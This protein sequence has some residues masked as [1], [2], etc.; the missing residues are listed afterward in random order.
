MKLFPMVTIPVVA[1]ALTTTFSNALAQVTT[2][3]DVRRELIRAEDEG[4]RFVTDASYP[5][6][7]PIYEKQVAQMQARHARDS[8]GTGISGSS[9]SGS[10]VEKSGAESHSGP[11]VGPVSYCNPYFGG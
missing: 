10:H 8:E 4:S 3:E 7:S 6:I 5:D 1:L 2:R 9:V 11:C